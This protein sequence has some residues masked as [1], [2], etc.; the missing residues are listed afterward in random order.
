MLSEGFTRALGELLC[1][2][3]SSASLQESSAAPL[4][5]QHWNGQGLRLRL[6]GNFAHS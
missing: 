1:L 2:A 4:S 3:G 6:K 5:Q